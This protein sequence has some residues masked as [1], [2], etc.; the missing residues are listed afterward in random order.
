V[1]Q[2]LIIPPRPEI[3]LNIQKVMREE[4]PDVNEISR[5][6]KEDI[7]LYSIF[8]SAAN[9]PWMGLTQ[10]ATSIEHAVMLMGLDRIYTMIQ[11]I[12]V[13]NT[14]TDVP[15]KEDFWT[16]AI[17]VAGICSDFANR[18]SGFDR[19]QAY[20]IGMLHNVGIP[21]MIQKH[22]EFDE[23]MK[24]HEQTP[25]DLL[26]VHERHKFETDHFLQGALMARQWNL[27]EDV[28]LAIR[29]QPL[30]DKILTKQK[31]IDETVATYLAILTIAK[32]ISAEYRRYWSTDK[33]EDRSSRETELALNYLHINHS[34]F[35]EIKD[36]I[37]DDYM[38]KT[39]A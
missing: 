26:C 35:H 3:L 18:F 32:N 21:I 34:D 19:N 28:T 11:A 38:S 8:L 29:Y 37:F 15:L 17:D 30:V 23:F 36:D 13:R 7:S 20:S 22:P 1:A 16:T 25:T 4:E 14:F 31:E 6:M 12:M 9:S 27:G 5:L 24:H 2:S 33:S 10:P 39:T